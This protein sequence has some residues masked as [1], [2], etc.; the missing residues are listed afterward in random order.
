MERAGVRR[1]ASSSYKAADCFS[2]SDYSNLDLQQAEGPRLL[3]LSLGLQL[4]LLRD[5][6]YCQN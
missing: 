4:G 6:F 5:L 1:S 3:L 2:S